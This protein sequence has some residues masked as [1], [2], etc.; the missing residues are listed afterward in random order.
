MALHGLVN[1]PETFGGRPRRLGALPGE[2]GGGVSAARPSAASA[3]GSLL[4]C[5]SNCMRAQTGVRLLHGSQVRERRVRLGAHRGARLRDGARAENPWRFHRFLRLV[6]ACVARVQSHERIES[7][8]DDRLD[9]RR[10]KRRSVSPRRAEILRRY[11]RAGDIAPGAPGLSSPVPS[12]SAGKLL[13]RHR[14]GSRSRRVRERRSPPV[15]CI[16]SLIP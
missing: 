5:T 3:N 14:K 13:I 2:S 1:A 9:L 11:G 10:R 15:I 4:I 16:W 12:T 8:F 7:G 6:R